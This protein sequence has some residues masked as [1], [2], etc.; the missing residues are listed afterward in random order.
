MINSVN[1]K[2]AYTKMKAYA[3]CLDVYQWSISIG[4]VMVTLHLSS[5]GQRVS[6]HIG[7]HSEGMKRGDYVIGNHHSDSSLAA[8]MAQVRPIK[9]MDM[10]VA[11]NHLLLDKLIKLPFTNDKFTEI[12]LLDLEDAEFKGTSKDLLVFSK[13]WSEYDSAKQHLH[14]V[15][16]TDIGAAWTDGHQLL[17]DR[18]ATSK[19]RATIHGKVLPLLPLMGKMTNVLA[20]PGKGDA[21]TLWSF[22]NGQI[23]QTMNSK[24][25]PVMEVIPD[26][27][28][29]QIFG[30]I[31]HKPFKVTE[32]RRINGIKGHGLIFD[33]DGDLCFGIETEGHHIVAGKT[34]EVPE[35]EPQIFNIV[36]I[37]KMMD[38]T[39]MKF[40]VN[41]S[42]SENQP[43]LFR[44]EKYAYVIMP[45]RRDK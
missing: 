16:I 19:H 13:T 9:E 15:N 37:A 20:R 7:R 14:I 45:L 12:D 41:F 4:R 5:T 10:V 36:F 6:Y 32:A 8:K 43:F 23:L 38:A 28:K 40:I 21:K 24:Y 22:E 33:K 17:L 39:K 27:N 29:M 3:K 30:E 31:T 42:E 1:F 25:P 2:K 18:T 11:D 26:H 34:E 44:N 35:G